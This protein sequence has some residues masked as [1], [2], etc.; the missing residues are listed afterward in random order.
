MKC[1]HLDGYDCTLGLCGGRP[2]RSCCF[3]C[4]SYVGPARGAGDLVQA[5][6]ERTGLHGMVQRIVGGKCGGCAD[7]RRML[8]EAMPSNAAKDASK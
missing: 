6:T 5:V 7:R 2:A 1:E 3:R 8:N 4:D